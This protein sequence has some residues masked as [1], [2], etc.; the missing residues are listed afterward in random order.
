MQVWPAR[1]PNFSS[2]G[3]REI[4]SSNYVQFH[5]SAWP[6]K[7]LAI[8]VLHSPEAGA[9][10]KRVRS[11]DTVNLST[12]YW[13]KS[14]IYLVLPGNCSS[15]S[16]TGVWRQLFVY[17]CVY[18][19]PWASYKTKQKLRLLDANVSPS[20]VE[21]LRDPSSL[22]TSRSPHRPTYNLAYLRNNGV[23][24]QGVKLTIVARPHLILFLRD[25][26]LD[27][28]GWTSLLQAVAWLLRMALGVVVLRHAQLV[29]RQRKYGWKP[30]PFSWRG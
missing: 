24:A 19:F 11:R 4:G 14:L 15:G 28:A 13:T 8:T 23:V 3:G 29:T 27:L 18:P 20:S 16:R 30:M 2:R 21:S 26:K 7:S 12:K 22:T 25:E 1:L 9:V 5:T 10:A 6:M 17:W